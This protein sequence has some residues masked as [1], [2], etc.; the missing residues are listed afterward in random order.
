MMVSVTN[1]DTVADPRRAVAQLLRELLDSLP[2]GAA[3]D[4]AL[5]RAV[6]QR[7]AAI[8]DLCDFELKLAPQ[9]E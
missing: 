9:S 6:E 5:R 7:A 8:E 2:V 1:N 4:V 3:R